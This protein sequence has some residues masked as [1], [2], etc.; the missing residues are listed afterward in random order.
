MERLDNLE[1]LRKE[2]KLT[3]EQLSKLTG[4]NK[5]TIQR[6]EKGMYNVNDI[7]FSTLI[8]LCKALKCKVA[9]IVSK[10]LR[11]YLR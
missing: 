9:D 7:K 10:D 1:L 6:L 3:R 2:R 5:T 8:K 11:R 4:L